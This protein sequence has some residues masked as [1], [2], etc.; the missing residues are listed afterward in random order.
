MAAVLL[1]GS[2]GE[3]NSPGPAPD[4]EPADAE[5]LQAYIDVTEAMHAR[6]S[7]LDAEC[8]PDQIF[9]LL[10]LVTTAKV[11]DLV[12]ADHFEDNGFLVEWDQDFAQRYFDAYDAY[13]SGAPTPDAWRIA[14][15]HAESGTSTVTEDLLLGMNAHVNY[16]LAHSTY[17]MG[18]PQ[19]GK[20]DEFDRV[21]DAFWNVGGPVGEEMAARYDASQ[22]GDD[23]GDEGADPT[24]EATVEVLISW[25]ENAWANAVLLAQ[26][27]GN[28]V[29]TAAVEAK[30]ASESTAIAEALRNDNG[31]TATDRVAYCQASGHPPL[32]AD[33]GGPGYGD[34]WIDDA[35]DRLICHHPGT[36]HERTLRVNGDAWAAHRDHGDA[37]GA[38]ED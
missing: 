8:D 3:L 10:Y 23:S 9:A 36:E 14:F 6:W 15:E 21:N 7:A 38:C 17:A 19:D 30:I 11:G 28:P 12:V 4:P 18:L 37:E 26:A 32:A 24:G 1:S 34:D 16:D 27:E 2:I 33:L 35:P 5:H 13:H 25:R 31:D 29:A 20:K 22:G